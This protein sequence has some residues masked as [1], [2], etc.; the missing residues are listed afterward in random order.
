MPK[1]HS[2]KKAY[3]EHGSWHKGHN[4]QAV[5]SFGGIGVRLVCLDCG[6][7]V[8]LEAIST[9]ISQDESRKDKRGQT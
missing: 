1:A 9:P 7:S 2:T 3:L 4:V 6:V 5:A 8:D